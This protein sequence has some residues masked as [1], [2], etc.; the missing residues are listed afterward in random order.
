MNT[1]LV[2][3]V[4]VALALGGAVD[5]RDPISPAAVKSFKGWLQQVKACSVGETDRTPRRSLL[6]PII[7]DFLH[8]LQQ[9]VV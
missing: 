9:D 8:A 4:T 2:E 3:F 6:G 7:N 5:R 1:G